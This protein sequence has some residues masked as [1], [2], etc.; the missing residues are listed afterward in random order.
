MP[1]VFL[2]IDGHTV[3]ADLHLRAGVAPPVVF[4]HGVMA[5]LDMAPELFVDPD[6]ESWIAVSLPGHAPGRLA[7]GATIDARLFADLVARALEELVGG[8]P[9]VAVGW[10]TGGFAALSLAIHHPRRVAA[11]ASLAGFADGH[12]IGGAM[13]WVTRLAELAPAAAAVMTGLRAAAAWPWAHRV[14]A[15]LMAAPGAIL[16]AE[17]MARLHAA[18]RAHD[19]AS[20]RRVLAALRSCTIATRLGEIRVPVW[21]V[22]GAADPIIPRAEAERIAAAIPGARLTCYPRAGHLFFCEWPTFRDDL[23][24]WRRGLCE[25]P[26]DGQ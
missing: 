3:A 25:S 2:S 20:L 7:P 10:S 17:T 24:A 22:A 4:L 8:R 12:C 11:V 23:A 6:R 18:Y 5:S 13:A 1:R 16:P 14:M 21:V 9:V 26:P 19:P 15:R